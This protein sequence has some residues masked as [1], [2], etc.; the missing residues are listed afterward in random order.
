[1]KRIATFLLLGLG[2]PA[3]VV[4][5]MGAGEDEGAGYEVRAIFD[6]AAYI[7]KGEDVKVAGAVVG[8]VK[9]LDVTD[10]KKAA[11]VLEI[12]EAGF[13]PFREGASCT[14]RPQSLI[15]E[16]FVECTH[17]PG[18]RARAARRSRTATARARRC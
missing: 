10:D 15:G 12:N 16:K 14:V 7:V 9:S 11:I 6:N 17:R 8:Q 18:Q 1:M 3:L 4:F 5:G 2:L 13:A